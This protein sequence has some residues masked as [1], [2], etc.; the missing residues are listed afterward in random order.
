MTARHF[1][2]TSAPA[3]WCRRTALFAAQF[4]LLGAVLHHLEAISTPAAVYILAAALF[5]AVAALLLAGAALTGIWRHGLAGGGYAVTGAAVALLI[6]AGPLLYVP[7]LLTQP[8]LNDVATDTQA[9]PAFTALAGARPAGANPAAYPGRPSAARQRAAYPGIRTMTLERSPAETFD[10][11]RGAVE[12]MGWRIVAEARPEGDSEGRIEAVAKT[13]LMGFRDD[14][15]IRVTSRSGGSA[16]D[17]RSASR[18]GV[19]DFGTN[20]RRIAGLFEEVK[21]GLA[22][23]EK[24]AL[25]MALA[26]RARQASEMEQRRR[27]REKAEREKAREEEEARQR[28]L[29]E[30]ERERQAEQLRQIMEQVRQSGSRA[31]ADRQRGSSPSRGA[32]RDEPGPRAQRRGGGAARDA[33]KFFRQFGE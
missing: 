6:L 2:R 7:E 4:L 22:K 33:D 5:L 24:T 17:V 8:R 12:R 23:G 9:P 20:A 21:A 1:N 26:R 29:L 32:A 18:Y 14:V 3:L 16:V 15:V 31:S 25:E 19:H 13:P 28:A 11:V 27:E 30:A 10:L